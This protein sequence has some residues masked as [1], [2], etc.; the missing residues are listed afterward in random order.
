M[1]TNS[2]RLVIAVMLMIISTNLGRMICM[3]I[4][5]GIY[6]WVNLQKK[7]ILSPNL[8]S[9]NFPSPLML[10]NSKTP[11]PKSKPNPYQKNLNFSQTTPFTPPKMST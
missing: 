10:V 8:K 1:T 9:R 11:K 6:S 3:L 7:K 2:L 4:L 5:I